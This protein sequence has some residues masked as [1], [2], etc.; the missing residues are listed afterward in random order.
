MSPRFWMRLSNKNEAISRRDRIVQV[1]VMQGLGL[2]NAAWPY[3][4]AAL[5]FGLA[6]W[7]WVFEIVVYAHSWGIRGFDPEK[8]ENIDGILASWKQV[9]LSVVVLCL[10][11][12]PGVCEELSLIHI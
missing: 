8:I 6:T 9:P 10:G 4:I 5:L 3:W 12:V 1:F 7:P 11:V 2:K